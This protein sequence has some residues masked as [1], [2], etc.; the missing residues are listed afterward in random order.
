MDQDTKTLVLIGGAVALFVWWN[1]QQQA[2]AA[3]AA[4]AARREAELAA[5]AA[6]E[7]AASGPGAAVESIFAGAGQIFRGVV[8]LAT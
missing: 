7:T 1:G 6:R 2:E 8:E 4:E 5:L 3:R